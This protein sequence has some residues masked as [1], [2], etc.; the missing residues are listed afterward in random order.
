MNG[1]DPLA[2]LNLPSAVR[3]RALK[4]LGAI[5]QARTAADCARA[6]DRAEGFALGLETVRALNAASLEGLYLAFEQAATVR[7]VVL[8]Q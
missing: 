6:A 1:H 7:L 3:A 5:A 8:E 4:L 2:A